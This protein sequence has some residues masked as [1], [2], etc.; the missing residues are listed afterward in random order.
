MGDV[1]DVEGNSQS[2]AE[3]PCIGVCSATQWGDAICKGCG[4]TST[5][6]GDWAILPSVYKKLV[7]I[8]AIGEGYTPRQVQRYTPDNALKKS[9]VRVK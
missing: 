8:R 3:S 4:R 6:I 2:L 1:M 5:E 7:V 9:S